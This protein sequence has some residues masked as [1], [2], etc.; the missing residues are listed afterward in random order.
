MGISLRLRRGL[1]KKFL[2]KLVFFAYGIPFRSIQRFPIEGMGSPRRIL[3]LNGAHIGDI[4]ISTSILPILR[5][6]YP[7]AEIGFAVGT[8]SSM[9]VENHQEISFIHYLDH[10][11]HNRNGKSFLKRYL[12]Y[13]KTYK[14]ALREIREMHYDLAMCIY[15]YPFPDFMDI[16]WKAGIPVRLGFKE[17]LFVSLA[18]VAVAV[19]KNPFLHQGAIQAEVL[20]PLQL[21]QVHTEKRKP[22]LPESTGKA[23]QEVCQLLNISGISDVRYRVIHIGAGARHRELPATFWRELAEALSKK[24]ILIFTGHGGR[25]AMQIAQIIDGLDHCINA[26]NSLSWSGFVAAVRHAEAL[27]GIESMAGHVAGAVG[28]RCIVVYTG[29]AGVVR[30]RPEGPITVISNHLECAPCGLPNGCKAMTCI[31]GIQPQDLI[32]QG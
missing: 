21:A 5:S 17:S 30:W 3:L 27:Y 20:R 12:Q 8:W 18:S 13:R 25:E 2:R 31:Q 11:R 24:H 22:I 19:P 9:V 4:V 6:A 7:S 16:A 10:W 23:I 29:A 1:L 26:C 28:T 14:A 15:P 32:D